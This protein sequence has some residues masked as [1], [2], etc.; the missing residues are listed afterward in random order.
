[1]LGIAGPDLRSVA[2]ERRATIVA[3]VAM[4]DRDRLFTLLLLPTS[5]LNQS[6][7]SFIPLFRFVS[8]AASIVRCPPK[9]IERVTH[10]SGIQRRHS[11]CRTSL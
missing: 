7:L 3:V 4:T 8:S 11:N 9:S 10:V 6:F 1:M 2:N 5:P